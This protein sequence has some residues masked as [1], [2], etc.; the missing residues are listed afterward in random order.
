MPAVPTDILIEN[1]VSDS[2]IAYFS[3]NIYLNAIPTDIL[4]SA[5]C[6]FIVMML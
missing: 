4:T 2:I 6:V 5:T 3:V 1:L